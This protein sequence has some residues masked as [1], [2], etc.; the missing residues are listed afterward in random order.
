MAGIFAAVTVFLGVLLSTPPGLVALPRY[1][2]GN[3]PRPVLLSDAYVLAAAS[4]LALVTLVLVT[5]VVAC[6][7]VLAT[8]VRPRSS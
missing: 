6:A 4:T 7:V 2:T 3:P 1:L 8:S 5:I